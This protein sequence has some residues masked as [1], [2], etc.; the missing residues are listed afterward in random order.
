MQ[1]IWAECKT[2]MWF[3]FSFKETIM[4]NL[5]I[6]ISLKKTSWAV[7]SIPWSSLSQD[8]VRD[9]QCLFHNTYRFSKHNTNR[10]CIKNWKYIYCA[11]TGI[12]P[13][14]STMGDASCRHP[15]HSSRANISKTA[16][17]EWNNCLLICGLYLKPSIEARSI[18]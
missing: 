5:R 15:N 2:S 3:N 1:N 4:I 16:S 14:M 8:N 9:H 17:V 6:F 12:D 11:H 7:K 18:T 10:I 13:S